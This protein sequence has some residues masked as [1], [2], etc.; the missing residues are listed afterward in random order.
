MLGLEA[1]DVPATLVDDVSN[2]LRQRVSASPDMR[3]VSGKDLVELKLVFACADEGHA[4][5]AQAGKSLDADKLIYG[6]VKKS[7]A[8][9]A[10]W[11][12]LFDV[13]KEKLESWLTETLPASQAD[14][15]GVRAAAGRWF[16]KLTGHPLNAGTLL[17]AANPFG[18]TLTLDGIPV[19]VSS[20]QPLTLS[21][22]KPGKHEVVA[23][24]SGLNPARQQ[25][26]VAVGQTV[27]VNLTLHEGA[28]A[29]NGSGSTRA[30]RSDS[31]VHRKSESAASSD[32]DGRS[33]YRTGFWVTMG[34]GLASAGAAVK[35]GLDVLKINKD[36]DQYRRYP[37]AQNPLES[38]DI[39]KNPAPLSE[40]DRATRDKKISEGERD[41]NLQW[42]FIGIGS[43]LGITSAYLLYKGYLDSDDTAPSH[44]EAK[45][46]L[47]IFPTAGVTSGGILAEFDF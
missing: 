30:G 37:C 21:E 7:G 11:L 17:I 29:E 22:V 43:A 27:S 47:R 13:R 25:F 2:E 24:K 10:V 16:S 46:G 1:I 45:S 19:G 36:L 35:F 28:M 23:T 8:D 9:F 6:S 18:A 40:Q 33:G 3:L 44:R 14:A 31:S 15:A 20:E 32:D 26:M 4:C 39:M 38:C 34:A 5:M 12:K 41:R 42:V